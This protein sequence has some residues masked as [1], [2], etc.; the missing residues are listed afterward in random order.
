MCEVNVLRRGKAWLESFQFNFEFAEMKENGVTY[1]WWRKHELLGTSEPAGP[2]SHRSDPQQ[3]EKIG[4]SVLLTNC[5][6]VKGWQFGQYFTRMTFHETRTAIFIV[7]STKTNHITN[8]SK[9][10][11]SCVSHWTKLQSTD[12]ESQWRN[13]DTRYTLSSLCRSCY[14]LPHLRVWSGRWPPC[15]AEAHVA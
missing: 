5:L 10:Q 3:T 11:L 6:C 4:T 8:W 12:W 9:S 1:C 2:W 13:S 15:W 14:R 7:P